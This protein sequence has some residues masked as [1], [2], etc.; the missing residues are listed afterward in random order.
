[1]PTS[2][3]YIIRSMYVRNVYNTLYR[4]TLFIKWVYHKK[5]RSLKTTDIPK[6]IHTKLRINRDISHNKSKHLQHIIE[7]SRCI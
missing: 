7:A 4:V 3:P 2:I 1:M 6:I 5:L